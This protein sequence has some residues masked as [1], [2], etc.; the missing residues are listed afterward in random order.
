MGHFMN[1]KFYTLNNTELH[2]F[3]DCIYT[4]TYVKR[5]AFR[6]YNHMLLVIIYLAQ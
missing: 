4:W 2:L 5:S 1:I 3:K 6:R